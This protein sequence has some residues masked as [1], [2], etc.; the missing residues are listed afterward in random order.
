MSYNRI[1]YEEITC[2]GCFTVVKIN[3]G[4]PNDAPRDWSRMQLMLNIK[5]GGHPSEPRDSVSADLCPSCSKKVLAS[6]GG[7]K[8]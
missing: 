1:S 6:L 5:P 3:E 8:S 4:N 7:Q 2:D